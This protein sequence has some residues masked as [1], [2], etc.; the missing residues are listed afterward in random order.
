MKVPN[1]A[2]LLLLTCSTALATEQ[3]EH[4]EWEWRGPGEAGAWLQTEKRGSAVTFSLELNRGE[5]SYNIGLASGQFPLEHHLG[6]Y[7]PY[8]L[9]GCALA[10]AFVGDEVE[11]KQV[12]S[13]ADCGFGFGVMAS[14]V[15][16]LKQTE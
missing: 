10:F 14:H 6:I 13:D 15:L 12:G 4:K 16:T 5:P 2:L 1:T 8:E 7:Q 11:I 3:P 9:P